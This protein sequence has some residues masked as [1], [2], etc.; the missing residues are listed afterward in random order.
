VS[1]VAVAGNATNQTTGGFNAPAGSF[2]FFFVGYVAV[3]IGGGYPVAITDSLG[4]QYFLVSSTDLAVNHSEDLYLGAAGRSDPALTVTVS[5]VSAYPMVGTVSVVDVANV[6]LGEINAVNEYAAVSG[7][8]SVDVNS[9]VAKNLYLLGAIAR[10]LAAPMTAEHGETLLG[11]GSA[12]T[13][14][15]ED[16]MSYGAFE[17]TSGG[18]VTLSAGLA[19]SS[20]PWAAIGVAITLPTS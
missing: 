16:G 2:V 15:F 11:T 14:P 7:Y 10:G 20:S 17:L 9:T 13:G 18:A 3:T 6:T 12:T 4:D 8:A 5:F 1:H 19:V